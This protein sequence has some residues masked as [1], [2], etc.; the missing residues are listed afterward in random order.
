MAQKHTTPKAAASGTGS[1]PSAVVYPADGTVSPF[2]VIN[3]G[4]GAV[5]MG[6]SIHDRRLPAL[7]FG[8][9]GK[10]MGHE[11]ALNREAKPGETLAVVT[12]ANVQGLDVLL[13]VLHRIRRQSFPQAA[14]TFF[15]GGAA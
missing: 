10:G 11:E 12:F 8:K 14:P 7:W 4:H 15:E 5:Q 13:Q 2:T 3:L 9:E 6:D 1:A